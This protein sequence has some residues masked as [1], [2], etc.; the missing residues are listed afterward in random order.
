VSQEC[1]DEKAVHRGHTV[2]SGMVPPDDDPPRA[3]DIPEE[4]C[5]GGRELRG[6]QR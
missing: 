1:R 3:C 6:S 2:A 4:K 5:Q